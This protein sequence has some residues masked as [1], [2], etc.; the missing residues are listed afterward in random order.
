M[1]TIFFNVVV[2][3]RIVVVGQL[4]TQPSPA[5]LLT[6]SPDWSVAAVRLYTVIVIHFLQFR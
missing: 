1:K 5:P 3:Q 2:K 4:Y 6:E